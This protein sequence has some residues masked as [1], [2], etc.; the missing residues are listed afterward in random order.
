MVQHARIFNVQ[1]PGGYQAEVAAGRG[2][3]V[4]VRIELDEPREV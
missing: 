4:R 1:F 2:E 3:A